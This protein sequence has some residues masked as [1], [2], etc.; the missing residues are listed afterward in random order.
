MAEQATNLENLVFYLRECA[1]RLILGVIVMRVVEVEPLRLEWRNI[2]ASGKNLIVAGHLMAGYE[3][4][5]SLTTS[6][7]RRTSYTETTTENV[8]K[9][10]DE[11][12]VAVSGTNQMFFAIDKAVRA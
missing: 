7:G 2:H 1:P 8:L 10:G 12:I 11:V 4:S 5:V 3:R 6:G 9:V